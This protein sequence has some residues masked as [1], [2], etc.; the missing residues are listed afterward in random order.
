MM[1]LEKGPVRGDKKES[2]RT[3]GQPLSRYNGL[4][5][6]VIKPKGDEHDRQEEISTKE[7]DLAT[8]GR[9][10]GQ[11]VQGLPDARGVPRSQYTSISEASRPM[12]LKDCW[13]SPRCLVNRAVTEYN[14]E[15]PHSS[16]DFLSPDEFRRLWERNQLNIYKPKPTQVTQN[17]A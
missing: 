6:K 16:L 5:H 12:G 1:A 13:T 14:E 17:A 2:P 11:R 10:A 4:T 8:T 9:E 15:H 3:G 7:V